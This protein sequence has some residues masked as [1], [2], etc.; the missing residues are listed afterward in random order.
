MKYYTVMVNGTT[1]D[2][3]VEETTNKSPVA[4]LDRTSIIPKQIDNNNN[5]NQDSMNKET[6]KKDIINSSIDEDKKEENFKNH[7]MSNM[8][9][10]LVVSAPMPGKILEVKAKINQTVKRGDVL[11]IL[12]AMKMENE[13]VAPEDGTI[14]SIVISAGDNVESGD[15]LTYMN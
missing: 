5:Q 8:T 11:F 14:V 2:V 12:E 1:Y 6:V 10:K 13:I 9:G 15:I 4:S 3:A 7:E